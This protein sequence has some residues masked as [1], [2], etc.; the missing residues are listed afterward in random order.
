MEPK[1]HGRIL[2]AV[3]DIAH[4]IWDSGMMGVNEDYIEDTINRILQ[5]PGSDEIKRVAR[6]VSNSADLLWYGKSVSRR[7]KS[8][9][10]EEI[11]PGM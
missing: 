7:L 9:Q 2:R 1:T 6:L 5:E 10:D 4:E 3:E 8:K 11:E